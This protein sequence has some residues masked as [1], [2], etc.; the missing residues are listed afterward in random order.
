MYKNLRRWKKQ[1]EK[2]GKTE[3][4]QKWYFTVFIV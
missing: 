2:E 1:L 4:A 3:E